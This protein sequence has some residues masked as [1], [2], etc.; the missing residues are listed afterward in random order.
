MEMNYAVQRYAATRPWARRVGQLYTQAVQAEAVQQEGMALVARELERAAQVYPAATARIAIE[1]RLA[2]AYGQFCRHGRLMAHLDD[3]LMLALAHT[4]LPG[5]MPDRLTLP[6]EAFYLHAAALGGAFVMH[7]PASNAVALLLVHADFSATGSDWLADAEHSLA[8]LVNYPGELAA[9]MATVAAEWHALLSTVLGGLA[10]MTQP[11]LEMLRGW[12]EA[13]PADAVALASHPTCAKS[14]KKG[15]SQLLQ[16][17][18]QEVSY[19]RMAGVAE[20]GTGYANQGYWR[21][22]AL[23]DAQGGSRL[24]WVMPR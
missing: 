19:C 1:Q 10:V 11:K 16:A 14:R 9:P 8:L 23:S 20:A 15:R 13:A 2:D 6:A 3:K 21:R 5:N 22:Q 4:R 17:G 18:F 7:L 12:E 24:V